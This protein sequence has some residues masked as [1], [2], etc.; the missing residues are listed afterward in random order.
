MASDILQKEGKT[1]VY[2]R[3]SIYYNLQEGQWKVS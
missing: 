1:D 3:E 2:V